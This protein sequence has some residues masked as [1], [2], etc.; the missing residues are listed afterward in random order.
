MIAIVQRKYGWTLAEAISWVKDEHENLVQSFLATAKS[1]PS[2]GDGI[3]AEV[4]SYVDGL[5]QWVRANEAWSF[6]SAR[7]FGCEGSDVQK[8][9]RVKILPRLPKHAL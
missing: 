1:L 7:Y 6:E 8:H 5:G 4:R 9:R 2:F 3:D